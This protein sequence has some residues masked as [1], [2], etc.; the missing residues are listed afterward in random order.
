MIFYVALMLVSTVVIAIPNFMYSSYFNRFNYK[1]TKDQL[2]LISFILVTILLVVVGSIRALD[3]GNDVIPYQGY[4]NNGYSNGKIEPGYIL[5]SNVIKF[6]SNNYR[7]LLFFLQILSVTPVMYVI[8]KRSPIQWLS[9]FMYHSMYLYVNS[10]NILRQAVAM[11]FILLAYYFLTKDESTTLKDKFLYAMCIMI[12]AS[13][14][15]ISMAFILLPIIK[16]IKIELKHLII[17]IALSII[18]FVLKDEIIMQ[19]LSILGRPYYNDIKISFGITTILIFSLMLL[20]S[21]SS[22]YQSSFSQI[23]NLNINI[24]LLVLIFNLFWV[25]FPNHARV[26]QFFML[27]SIIFFPDIVSTI[28]IKKSRSIVLLIVVLF[29]TT[30]YLFQLQY[31]DQGGV[32]PYKIE[33]MRIHI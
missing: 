24:I 21:Y 13:F 4:F 32:V 23:H 8:Y 22:K 30:F 5:L 28:T 12:A 33:S 19:L 20:V 1:F 6:T 16:Y 31:R 11:A 27:L 2:I 18:I 9:V 15:I 25:W 17:L 10:F 3:V 14:H 7:V 29:F 26:S